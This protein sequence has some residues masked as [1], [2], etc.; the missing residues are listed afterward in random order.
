MYTDKHVLII[1]VLEYAMIFDFIRTLGFR[2]HK[3]VVNCC[4]F[5]DGKRNL[6]FSTLHFANCRIYTN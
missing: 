1:I 5:R 3:V 2:F 4:Y 6:N